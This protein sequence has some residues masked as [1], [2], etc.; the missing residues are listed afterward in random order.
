MLQTFEKN[1]ITVDYTVQY[2][3][4]VTKWHSSA[5]QLAAENGHLQIVM[6]L[7]SCGAEKN[8]AKDVTG[9]SPLYRAASN[10][11]QKIVEFLLVKSPMP[12]N[13]IADI[14][15]KAHNGKTPLSIAAEYGHEAVVTLLL[16]RGSAV[17]NY[18]DQEGRTP[19]HAA[20]SNGHI[21]LIKQLIEKGKA[22]EYIKDK[23]GHTY[24]ELLPSDKKLSFFAE[25]ENP[26]KEKLQKDDHLLWFLII[27]MD[28][29]LPSPST[30]DN[31]Q[32]QK[33]FALL[34]EKIKFLVSAYPELASAKDANGR[35]AVDIASKPMRK[36]IE[37]VVFFCGQYCIQP[38]PPIHKSAT[39]VVVF[40]EDFKVDDEYAAAAAG[41]HMAGDGTSSL[42]LAMFENALTVLSNQGFG[43]AKL[44]LDNAKAAE[45]LL[46]NANNP[47]R[48]STHFRQCDKNND[49]MVSINEFVEY[50]EN[51][52]GRSLKMAI[53]FMRNKDQFLREID[54]RN[55][56]G[57]SLDVNYVVGISRIY[58]YQKTQDNPSGVNLK[59]PTAFRREE[60]ECCDEVILDSPSEVECVNGAAGFSRFYAIVMEVRKDKDTNPTPYQIHPIYCV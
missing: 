32:L 52:L 42:N 46:D 44:L 11:H 34:M 1:K 45:L 50:C 17:I 41:A 10:G 40:A 29:P 6:H 60:V 8:L 16:D 5:L 13:S 54:A 51:I 25:S 27:Q 26:S 37:S 14:D 2:W 43:K 33:L 15:Q 47:S 57:K 4:K 18:P 7:T 38:G 28:P 58:Y 24:L 3:D 36:I 23:G 48:L 20:A 30:A 9:T 19:L 21:M 49:G 53:K 55:M 31:S 39:A 35:I 56:E 12:Y 22:D 59:L